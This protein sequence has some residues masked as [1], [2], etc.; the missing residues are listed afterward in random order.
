MTEQSV[1]LDEGF[2][3]ICN[4]LR[5]EHGGMRHTF[6]LPGQPVDTSQFTPKRRNTHAEG[7]DASTPVQM[8]VSVSQTPFDPALRLVLIQKG[9]VTSAELAEAMLTISATTMQVTEG[10]PNG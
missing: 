5:E 3:M 7:D 4:H 10:K 6:T 2:C 9:I 1:P 8:P